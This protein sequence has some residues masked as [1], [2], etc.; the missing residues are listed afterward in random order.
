[1]AESELVRVFLPYRYESLVD[2]DVLKFQ[3]HDYDLCYGLHE[4]HNDDDV[5]I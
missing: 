4:C 3:I 2:Q 5:R 1:M